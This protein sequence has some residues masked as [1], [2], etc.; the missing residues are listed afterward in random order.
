MLESPRIS[1]FFMKLFSFKEFFSLKWTIIKYSLIGAFIGALP[2]TGATISSVI[3]YGDAV[4]SS[5]YPEKF[6]TGILEGIA[7]PESANNASVVGAM[8]PTL[9]LGIPGSGATA[10][11]LAAL[12]MQG[13]QPGPLLILENPLFFNIVFVTLVFADIVMVLGAF[14]VTKLFTYFRRVPCDTGG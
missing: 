12:I 11:I 9:V 6:G 1:N 8:I 13:V 5:K 4:R 3:A 10:I 2:G 7:A 14:G